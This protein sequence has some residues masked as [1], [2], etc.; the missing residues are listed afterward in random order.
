MFKIMQSMALIVLVAGTFSL[1]FSA[2]RVLY[3]LR[4]W[5]GAPPPSASP[6]TRRP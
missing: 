4:R 5:L 1:S 3:A 6:S 2:G